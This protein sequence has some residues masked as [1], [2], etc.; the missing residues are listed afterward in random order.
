MEAPKMEA[1]VDDGLAGYYLCTT[2]ESSVYTR[3]TGVLKTR[4]GMK[5]VGC[6]ESL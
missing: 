2:Q 6:V 4:R 5:G 1:R 3:W